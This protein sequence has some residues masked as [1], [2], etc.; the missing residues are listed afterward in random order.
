MPAL[1]LAMVSFVSMMLTARSFA[2]KNGYEIDA[3]KE[4]RAL[5]LANIAS[6]F[7]QGFA[8]SGADSRT[9]VNDTNGGKTQLVSIIAALLIALVALYGTAPLQY[10]PEAAL[11]IVLVIA[12]TSLI[13]LKA[14]WLLRKRDNSAFVLALITLLAVLFIGV[15]PGITL[16]VLLGLFQFLHSV[17][18][19]TD[20]ILGLN[21]KGIIRSIDSSNKSKPIQGVFIY[22]FNSPLTYFNAIYFKRRVLTQVAAEKE[23]E[24]LIIDAVPSFTHFDLSVMAMLADLHRDLKLR[25]IRLILAGRKRQM[26]KWCELAGVVTSEGGILIRSDLYLALKMNQAYLQALADG[27]V[28]VLKKEALDQEKVVQSN[29]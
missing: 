20:Q 29:L 13:D 3:D 17:M 24:C 18:R 6:A 9:A 21:E 11:G 10:I 5:G 12:S 14:L 15:I 19:P 27:A 26:L 23:T 16:A 22:R 25:G 7:S 4:F 2:A 1:N 8:V 28:P